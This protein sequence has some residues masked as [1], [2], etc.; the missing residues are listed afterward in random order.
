[1]PSNSRV[2]EQLNVLC[3]LAIYFIQN[4]TVKLFTFR[5]IERG[6]EKDNEGSG[7][8]LSPVSP[9][10]EKPRPPSPCPLPAGEGKTVPPRSRLN[11]GEGGN[12]T[13]GGNIKSFISYNVTLRLPNQTFF[14]PQDLMYGPSLIR[15]DVDLV[16][17]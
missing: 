9:K 6:E 3:N 16:P 1:M 15:T 4:A 11:R 5:I 2:K 8:D 10:G 7:I 12:T 13:I 14:A 17:Q